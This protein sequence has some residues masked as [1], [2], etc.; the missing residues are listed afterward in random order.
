MK[1]KKLVGICSFSVKDIDVGC[2]ECGSV[3]TLSSHTKYQPYYERE[4]KKILNQIV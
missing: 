1:L 4:A 3:L 2:S